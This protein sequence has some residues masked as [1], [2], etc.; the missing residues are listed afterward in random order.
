MTAD[1]HC[2]MKSRRL[3]VWDR[4]SKVQFLVDTGADLCV[5]PR[6]RLRG[7]H[8]KSSYE[9]S[10][11]NGTPIAT[12]GFATLSLNL[13]LRREFTWRFVIADVSKPILGADFLAHYG[14]L[15]DLQKGQLID[16]TTLLTF[17]GKIT[18]CGDPSIKTISGSSPFHELL[19]EFPEITRPEGAPQQVK[20][21]TKHYII[22][23]P[24]PP[25]AQKP[26][27]LAPDR[28]RAAKR[29]FN[30]ML[31]LGLARPGKGSWA[32]PLHM[33]PKKGDDEWRA[34]GDYRG[35]NV[36]TY[37]DKY[38]VRH[39][40]DFAQ[41]LDGKSIFSKIDCT[42]AYTQIPVAEEDIP[43]TA[44]ITPF[45]LFEFPF[46][47]FGLRNAAQTFQRFI[48]E[49]LQGLDFVYAYIDDI[50]IAS[51]SLDEHMGH[52]RVVC[53]RLKQY[54]LVINPSKCVF[55]Q[56]QIEFLGYLVSGAGTQPL[57]EKVEAIRSFKLPDTVKK[58]RGF[59]GMINFYRR[60]IPKAAAVQAPLNNL[61]QGNVKGNAP[62]PWTPEAIKAFDACKDS[63]AEATLLAHPKRDAPLAIFSDAS[64]FAVGAALQQKVNGHWQPLDFF[65]KKLSPT[66]QKY[67]AY[68]RE[69]LAIYLSVKHFR[70]MIEAR[71]FTIFTDHKPI[72]FALKKKSSQCSPRQ[73]RHLDFISQYSP[74]RWAGQR[75]R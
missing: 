58:L 37:P 52:L 36:R 11:A 5:F 24:G 45:G 49:V 30:A 10:A 39:I 66:E 25:V 40:Q 69:L 28:L 47:T 43:K 55:G 13:G 23:S 60:F 6:Q 62:V 64:D 19:R 57:P 14:L 8:V 67:G 32:S 7:P 48:D 1:D 65:S 54:G 29:E 68:D 61:L 9:L 44:I 33:V 71:Q 16:S 27:R 20:H 46:M 70:H 41:H 34:C 73:F 22:T 50:L 2:P 3:F 15:P 53:E 51:A 26:R 17:K 75:R 38:G 21:N 72:T 74:Y 42:R 56:P 59:L 18:E 63:L 35:L 4:T 12:Y 31:R